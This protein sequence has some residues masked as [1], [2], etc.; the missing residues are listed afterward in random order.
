MRY[1]DYFHDIYSLVVFGICSIS[2]LSVYFMTRRVRIEIPAEASARAWERVVGFIIDIIICKFIHWT[3]IV[4]TEKMGLKSTE[5]ISD[6]FFLLILWLYF[7]ILESSKLQATL[8]KV[9]EETMVVNV[10]GERISFITASLRLLLK[11][12]STIPFCIGHLVIFSNKHRRSFHDMAAHTV[13]IKK[14][15]GKLERPRELT[16]TS[17][18]N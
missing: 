4:V 16:G 12:V 18:N 14:R 9:A 8:G 6:A 7:S 10:K 15:G 13:V 5:L 11:F 3:I 17:A 2:I 1:E